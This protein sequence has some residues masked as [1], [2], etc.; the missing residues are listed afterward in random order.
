MKSMNIQKTFYKITDFLSWHKNGNLTLCPLFQRRPIWREGTKSYLIDTISKGL[1]IPPIFLRYKQT[2]MNTFEPTREVVDGQQRLRTVI[3]YINPSSLDDFRPER[4]YFTVKSTHNKELAGK[5]FREL[6]ENLQRQ[7]LEYEFNVHIFPSFAD[8]RFIIQVFRRMNSTNY[9][10]NAQE[11]R[12]ALYFGEFKT[13]MYELAAEQLDRWRKWK[14]FTED[15]LA[16]MLEVELTSE[17]ALLMLRGEIIGKTKPSIDKAYQNYDEEYTERLEVEKRFRIVMDTIDE[18]FGHDMPYIPFHRRTLMYS[19][20]ACVYDALFGFSSSCK[21]KVDSKPL[22]I[23]QIAQIK[24]AGE[25]IE[26]KSA[27]ED[28]LDAAARRTTNPKERTI[29]FSYLRQRD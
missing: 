22:P 5:Q 28:V 3:A 8:D 21:R 17:F 1:P 4:D 11:L 27:P 12:N 23:D 15:S 10:L 29:L 14:T 16:R 9:S 26:N 18:T 13:S 20:F 7:I 19:F 24:K 6:P 25:R 2:D